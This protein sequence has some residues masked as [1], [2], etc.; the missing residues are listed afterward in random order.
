M[1]NKDCETCITF[2]AFVVYLI[3]GQNSALQLLL[4]NEVGF[5][6]HQRLQ[7]QFIQKWANDIYKVYKQNFGFEYLSIITKKFW[8]P[9][10]TIHSE[11]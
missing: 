8:K 6:C 3:S 11:H 7:E 2:E 5:C 4:F 9:L 1:Y 10:I